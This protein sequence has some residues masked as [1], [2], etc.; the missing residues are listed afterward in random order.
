MVAIQTPPALRSNGVKHNQQGC[1]MN[2]KEDQT[3]ALPG[4]PVQKGHETHVVEPGDAKKLESTVISSLAQA[5]QQ[6]ICFKNEIARLLAQVAALREASIEGPEGDRLVMQLRTANQNL[7]IATLDAQDMQA[8]AE[9]LIR[10]QDEFL[11]MLA[12]ELRNPLA[13]I[14]MANES[15]GIL[16]DVHPVLPRLHAIIGRQLGNLTHIVDELLDAS[17]VMTGKI[18]LRKQALLLSEVIDGAIE[19]CQ[20]YADKRHQKL[21]VDVRVDSGNDFPDDADPIIVDGDKIRLIQAFSNLL[22]NATKFTQEGGSITVSTARLAN[23]V[24]VFIKDNG[25]G[26]GPELQPFIFDLFTQGP[27]SLERTEGGLGIGLSLVRTIAELHGGKVEVSSEGDGMGSEF[28]LQLPISSELLP[29]DGSVPPTQIPVR[30][31]R[32]LVIE[33]NADSNSL[34]N[35]ILAQEGHIMTSAFDGPSG[36]ALATQNSYDVIICDIGLPGM[37]GY[38]VIERLQLHSSRPL[39]RLIAMTGYNQPGNQAR[40]AEAGFDHYLVKP[41]AMRNLRNLIPTDEP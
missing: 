9:A 5:D 18:T 2:P 7:V 25:V 24:N 11:A 35:N 10:R 12:H 23:T 41:V 33:D 26:I 19:T 4:P 15:L 27:R 37:S 29:D 8:A 16:Q 13:P 21:S 38:E 3:D 6:T 22:I 30:A 17:R 20:P 1:F 34:L 31:R 28:K 39:P 32:I 14:A 40:A 36:L